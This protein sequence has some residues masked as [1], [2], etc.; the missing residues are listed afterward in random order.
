MANAITLAKNYTS[1]LDEVY[2]NAATTS[3]LDSD[4][5]TARAGQT[6]TRS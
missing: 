6:Q 4:P 2:K 1:L 5:A 3:V